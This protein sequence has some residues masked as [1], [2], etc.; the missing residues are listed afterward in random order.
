MNDL[1]MEYYGT[2]EIRDIGIICLYGG[3][4]G[5]NLGEFAEQVCLLTGAIDLY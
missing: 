5:Y 4:S 1:R 2:I 3:R